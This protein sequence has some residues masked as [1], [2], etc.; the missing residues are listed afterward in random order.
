MRKKLLKY[1]E[2][3]NDIFESVIKRGK[4]YEMFNYNSVISDIWRPIIHEAQNF[5]NISFDLENNDDIE[6]K[7]IY[8]DQLLRIDQPVKTEI[9]VVLCRAGGDWEH[10]ILYFKIEFTHDHFITSNRA[11][12]AQYIWDYTTDERKKKE[13]KLDYSHIGRKFCIIPGKDINFLKEGE[14]GKLYAYTDDTIKEDGLNP[15]DMKIDKNLYSKAWKWIEDLMEKLS[16]ERHKRLDED[17]DET[18]ELK[19]TE[20]TSE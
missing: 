9:N 17:E 3:K 10:P 15:K 4:D 19:D 8:F 7:T 6:K 11:K 12:P 1:N 18:S 14:N 2:F 5:Q 13:D 16:K 20:E